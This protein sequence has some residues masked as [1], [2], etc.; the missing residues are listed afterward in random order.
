[1]RIRKRHRLKRK[2]IRRFSEE[3][4]D[5]IGVPVFT[6]EDVV[7]LGIGPDFEVIYVNGKVLA[8]VHE[9][10]PFPTVRGLLEYE[11]KSKF[12]TV[13]M[14]AVS[15]VANGADVMGPGIVDADASIQEGDLVWI[16][17]E[18][19]RQPLAV[20]KALAPGTEMLGKEKG[21][22]VRSLI[23]V[24]DKLWKLDED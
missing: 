1:M 7:D 14:G 18:K 21:K 23:Y 9:K 22:M 20:G 5:Q 15:F 16:R 11:A 24:G 10:K 8:F 3:I 6:E 2:E 4:S 13:D 17:D 19:N 12:V